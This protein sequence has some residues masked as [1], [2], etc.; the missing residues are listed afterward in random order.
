[1]KLSYSKK[2]VCS[3]LT[4]WWPITLLNTTYKIFAKALQRQLQPLLVEVIDSDQTAFLPL[5]FILDN[6]ILTHE[7]IQWVKELCQEFIFLKLDFS[8]TNDRVE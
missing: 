1:M 7:L 4:N 6:I 8:K 2:R 3:S 5:R